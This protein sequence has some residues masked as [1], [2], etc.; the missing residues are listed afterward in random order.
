M[1]TLADGRSEDETRQL[2]NGELQPRE[3][4]GFDLWVFRDQASEIL[5]MLLISL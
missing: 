4:Y 2:L 5:S 3:R 1:A